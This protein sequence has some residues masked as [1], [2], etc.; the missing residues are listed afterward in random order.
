LAPELARFPINPPASAGERIRGRAQR[1]W[2]LFRREE[3][4]GSYV[5]ARARQL[6]ERR[7]VRRLA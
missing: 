6:A 4:L 1:E 2:Q 3:R 5:A 7:S